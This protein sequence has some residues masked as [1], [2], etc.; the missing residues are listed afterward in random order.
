MSYECHIYS[1][2]AIVLLNWTRNLDWPL[3]KGIDAAP[4]RPEG[5]A[6]IPE[7]GEARAKPDGDQRRG[8]PDEEC[9]GEARLFLYSV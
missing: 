2:L 5:E 7:A 4:S 9:P 3:S 8:S 1:A 6:P